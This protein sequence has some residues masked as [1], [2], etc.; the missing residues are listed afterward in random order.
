M[1]YAYRHKLEG[2]PYLSAVLILGHLRPIVVAVYP[3]AENG[4][5]Q[6][7]GCALSA[8][9]MGPRQRPPLLATLEKA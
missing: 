1:P 2:G 6:A 8:L 7:N 9:K 5:V 4:T 3:N